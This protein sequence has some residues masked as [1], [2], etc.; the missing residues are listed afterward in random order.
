[1]IQ[2]E[3]STTLV[4]W[5]NE[6]MMHL[7]V[8]LFAFL[9]VKSENFLK[10]NPNGRV[11]ALVDHNKN[12]FT[13]WESGAILYYLVE[14]YDKEGKF[15]GKDV[16]EKTV[17]MQWLTFQLSGLGPV[18][19]NVNYA[20]HYW[21]PTYGEKPCKSVFTR[22]E[23][24]THRLYKVLEQ[25]LE[26]QNKKGSKFVATDRLSIADISFYTWVNIAG[27]GKVDL[28]PYKYVNEWLE[29]LR[30]DPQIQAADKK[31]PK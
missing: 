11:P 12:D 26:S 31:L 14:Q 25:Q 15:F 1:M 13:V 30:A 5:C 29:N 2:R 24:E 20:H 9:G 3:V 19:G 4:L 17:V 6:G 23:G 27:F 18:Q 8:G 10:V 16:A 21:E 7:L 22:F 28:S